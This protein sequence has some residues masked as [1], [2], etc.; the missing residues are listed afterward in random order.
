MT[1]Y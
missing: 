1:F